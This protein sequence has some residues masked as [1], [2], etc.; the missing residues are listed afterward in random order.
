MQNIYK[1]Y[2]QNNININ[3]EEII[4]SVEDQIDYI[5][6]LK[7]IKLQKEHLQFDRYFNGYRLPDGYIKGYIIFSF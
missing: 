3:I 6:S 2:K 5:K 1:V 7:L 4:M